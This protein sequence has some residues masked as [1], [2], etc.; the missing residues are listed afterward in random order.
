MRWHSRARK[1]SSDVSR[2][3]VNEFLSQL[4]GFDS[5]NDRGC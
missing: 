3:I 5:A 2:K 4:D 1:A